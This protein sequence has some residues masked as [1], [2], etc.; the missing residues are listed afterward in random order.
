MIDKF[1]KFMEVNPHYGYLIAA[2]GFGVYLLGL[3]L[4]WK[5]TLEAGGGY[6]NIAYWMEAF[7]EKTV[8]V[9][10][11]VVMAIAMLSCLAVFNYYNNLSS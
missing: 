3:I 2:I 9:V 5:W 1:L 4:N 7:G 8:R 10:M 11:A 6:F